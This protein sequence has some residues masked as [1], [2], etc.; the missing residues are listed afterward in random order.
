[1]W[2][3]RF[4]NAPG[5]AR[6]LLNWQVQAQRLVTVNG[7]PVLEFGWLSGITDHSPWQ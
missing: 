3:S 2:S 1:M 4:E 6:S 5:N 7:R